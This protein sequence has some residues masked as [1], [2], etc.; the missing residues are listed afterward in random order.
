MVNTLDLEEQIKAVESNYISKEAAAHVFYI[1]S[2]HLA[3]DIYQYKVRYDD[4][5]TCEMKYHY[6]L[7][8]DRKTKVVPKSVKN[9]LKLLFKKGRKHT[10]WFVMLRR[11]IV[12]GCW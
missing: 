1:S 9:E 10:R 8:D 12:L 7:S 2:V 5:D 6:F 4:D 11:F 3:K